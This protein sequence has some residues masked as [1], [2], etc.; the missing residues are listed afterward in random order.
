MQAQDLFSQAGEE[1]HYDIRYKY[2]IVDMKGGTA[3]Y[4]LKATTFDREQALE[5]TLSFRTNSFF[6][7][8]YRIRD[9]LRSYASVPGITPLYHIRNVNEGGS[10]L[11]EELRMLKHGQSATEV[12]VK[13]I[14]EG[15]VRMD[16]VI[17]SD[18]PGYDL[19]NI[20]LFIRTLD[21]AQLRYEQSFTVAT[22]LGEKKVNVLIKYQGQAV[23][24]KSGTGYKALRFA[25]DVANE[26]FT[27][28]KNAIEIWISDDKN[29]IPL[30]IKAKLKIG[31]AE[32]NLSSHRNLLHPFSSAIPLTPRK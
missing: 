30:K 6:D 21:Y 22:F 9:T 1:L 15:E 32:A 16:T 13:R 19:L 17:R 5:S 27:E 26:V 25:V 10:H 14:K 31:A 2:G 8:I 11:T 7:K 28:S 4:G 29:H 24:R 3:K 18:L 23:V 20:F 12:S